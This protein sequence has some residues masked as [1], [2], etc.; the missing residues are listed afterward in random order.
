MGRS[1][2]YHVAASASEWR[3]P[4]HRTFLPAARPGRSG[5]TRRWQWSWRFLTV[6]TA[7][8]FLAPAPSA[9]AER[10]APSSEEVEDVRPC[11][12]CHP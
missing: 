10:A 1:G 4:A 5:G 3:A 2:I 8:L 7:V 12:C 11:E 9:P 6:G